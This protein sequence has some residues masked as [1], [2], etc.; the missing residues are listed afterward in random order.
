MQIGPPYTTDIIQASTRVNYGQNL[1]LIHGLETMVCMAVEGAMQ[2]EGGNWQIFAGMLNASSANVL[3][4]TTVT[5]VSKSEGQYKISV[6]PTSRVSDILEV[7]SE[8]FDTVVLAGPLQFSMIG[9]EDGL[10]KHIPDD[11]PYVT[12]HVTLFTSP[13]K[14]NGSHFGLAPGAAAP[15]TVLTTLSP[16][17]D[18]SDRKKIVGKS[19]FFSISTLRSVTNPKTLQKEYLYKIFTPKKI[20]SDFLTSLL[21]VPRKNFSDI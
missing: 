5:A 14:L 13:H 2:I 4:N 12:L 15:D 17:E 10:L 8:T 19:G 18:L 9:V 3:L 1:G 16:D 6:T 21:G 7:T 20:H 11:I